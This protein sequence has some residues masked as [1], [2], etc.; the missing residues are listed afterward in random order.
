MKPK[1]PDESGGL[2]LQADE[3]LRL[4]LGLSRPLIK[5][6]PQVGSRVLGIME[7]RLPPGGGFPVAHLHDQ[8]EEAFY[9]LEGEIDYLIG[10][11]WVTATRD[12]TVFVPAG[13]PHAFRNASAAPARQLVIAS[14]EVLTMLEEMAKVPLDGWEEVHERFHSHYVRSPTAPDERSN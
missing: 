8:Y 6:G 9:V 12:T 1:E 2:V 4:E 14:A 11:R 10:D 13:T 3:G 7:G 5:V